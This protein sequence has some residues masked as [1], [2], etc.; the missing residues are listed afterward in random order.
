MTETNKSPIITFLTKKKNLSAVLEILKHSQDVG[1]AVRERFWDR[2]Q[3]VVKERGPKRRAP[4]LSWKRD[5]DVTGE[6]PGLNARVEP[7]VERVQGLEYYI[8]VGKGEFG[9]GLAWLMPAENFERL[10][11]IKAVQVLRKELSKK[12]CAYGEPDYPT[13]DWLWWEIWERSTYSDSDPWSWFARDESD[14]PWFRDK[15]D[16]FWDLATQVHPLVLEAN[17][18]LK[19]R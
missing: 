7:F 1:I 3:R 12:R 17:K 16:K 2:L 10:C 11:Q 19:G 18:A 5:A 4:K 8:V 9:A 15:A 6:W 14:G 13:E